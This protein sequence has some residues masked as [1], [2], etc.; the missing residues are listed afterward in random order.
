MASVVLGVG[1]DSLAPSARAA[2][3]ASCGPPLGLD[4]AAEDEV[5]R[6]RAARPAA[7]PERCC[8]SAA[9]SRSA[10]A[11]ASSGSTRR[12]R[13]RSP[14]PRSAYSSRARAEP[15][16]SAG[17]ASRRLLASAPPARGLPGGDRGVDERRRRASRVSAGSRHAVDAVRARPRSAASPPAAR[18]RPSPRRRRA[19]SPQ[20]AVAQVV[21]GA[22][23][24]GQLGRAALGALGEHGGVGRVQPYPL[25]GQ[26]VVVDRFGQQRVPERVAAPARRELQDVGVDRFAQRGVQP[27]SAGRSTTV[28]EHVVRAPGAR[29]PRRRAPPRGRRRTAGR[30]A[31]AAGRPAAT[32][33]AAGRRTARRRRRVPRRRRRCRRR[34]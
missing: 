13:C 4:V 34:A 18:P 30:D 22:R 23:V 1:R 14:P 11:V 15:A 8:G 29:R 16:A 21:R 33:A 28:G 12:T 26:Q 31:R 5:E 32:A 6:G 10:S 17:R 9:V 3:M 20:Y 24:A 27:R 7:H 25:A 19:R 2:S